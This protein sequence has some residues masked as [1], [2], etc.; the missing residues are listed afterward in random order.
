MFAWALVKKKNSLT[1]SS[2]GYKLTIKVPS[3]VSA[4][5]LFAVVIDE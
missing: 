5:K 4:I 3:A 2:T 1:S